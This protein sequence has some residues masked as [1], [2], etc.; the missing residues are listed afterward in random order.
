MSIELGVICFS[1]F[2]VI[3]IIALRAKWAHDKKLRRAASSG[4]YDFDVARYGTPAAGD[5]IEKSIT[6]RNQPL[7]PSFAASNRDAV[8]TSKA[9]KRGSKPV[10]VPS[11]F[12]DRSPVGL[13]P[14]FDLETAQRN[15]PRADE[16]ADP[17]S[18]PGPDPAPPLP[19]LEQPPPPA[20][21]PDP[22]PGK[23]A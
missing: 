7:A 12:G 13:P 15:R 22:S 10:P 19:L 17:T 20:S 16:P 23:P 21:D 1:V 3:M 2:M 4:F 11:S 6:E 18:E 5:L 8:G 14:A 9:G